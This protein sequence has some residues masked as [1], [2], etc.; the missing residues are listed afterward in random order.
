MLTKILHRHF[1]KINTLGVVG[2]GQMG[3]G[4]AIVA[5]A[6]SNLNVRVIDTEESRLS[7]SRKFTESWC[8]K[9]IK[10]GRLTSE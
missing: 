9:E 2:G 10:K 8:E 5:S 7:N 3:T 4:I 6:V 1:S